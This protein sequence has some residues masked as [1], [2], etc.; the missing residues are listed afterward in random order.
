MKELVKAFHHCRACGSGD[1]REVLDLGTHAVSDFYETPPAEELRAP[2]VLLQCGKCGLVQLSHSVS[3]D[4]LYH[5]DYWY[6]SGINETMVA[7]L[8]D[9]VEDA[10]SRVSLEPGDSVADI[11]ANDGTLLSLYPEGIHRVG[12]DPAF[13]AA[14]TSEWFRPVD[15]WVCYYWPIRDARLR[16]A[17]FEQGQPRVITSIA[18]FYDLDEPGAF[19]DEVAAWLH[20]EGV[21]INQ[22]MD[23]GSMLQANA[24]DNVCHEHV[25][26]WDEADYRAFLCQ[27]GL[28][29]QAT[30][31][32][33]V[34]GGSIRVVA[35]KT[36]YHVSVD[37]PVQ[38]ARLL[39]FGREVTRLKDETLA[40]LEECRQNG[41]T[42][43]GYGAS[44]KGNT[45]LQA[46][47]IT[48]DLLPAIA[49]RN[50]AKWGKVTA[51]SHI[52][53]ISEE[54]MRA[55]RPDYLLI[56]PWAFLDSFLARERGLREQGTRFIVPLPHL[57][58]V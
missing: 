5:G 48:P 23:L 28:L 56:L 44:T 33:R 6:R 57:R 21:W 41:K 55:R 4:R 11:G 45:L 19:V 26:Y 50:P 46:Y 24:F 43:L 29:W 58:V 12:V 37:H 38:T 7:A 8:K 35:G 42:V 13:R 54:E 31:E 18:C 22:M 10:R 15:R 16:Q 39:A 27:H 9:V 36:G 40:L 1:L 30:S 47:G 3:K 17:V 32:N 52:P 53:I 51:G 34:N 25:A 2:L 14:V 20:P 49:E